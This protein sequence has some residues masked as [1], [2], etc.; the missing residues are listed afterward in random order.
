MTEVEFVTVELK[1]LGFEPDGELPNG[2][3]RLK[4]RGRDLYATVGSQSIQI[5]TKP[6][7]GRPSKFAK[8]LIYQ[9]QQM[10]R[11]LSKVIAT[12]GQ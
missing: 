1:A 6:P 7:N 10:K 5:Y 4:L 12:P 9:R 3:Q 11:Y 8:F 2:R